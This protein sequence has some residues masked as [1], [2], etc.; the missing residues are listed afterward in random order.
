MATFD[1]AAAGADQP[2]WDLS[3]P[4]E[5]GVII[6]KMDSG[7]TVSRA[8]HERGLRRWS[9]TWEHTNQRTRDYVVGFVRDVLEASEVL[10]WVLPINF[11]YEPRPGVGPAT[12]YT[13]GGALAGTTYYIAY[14]WFNANGE[15]ELSP[16]VSRTVP[17]SHFLQVTVGRFPTGATGAYVYVGTASGALKREATVSTSRGTW[18]Q[19]GALSGSVDPATANGMS[20]TIRARIARGGFSTP[21]LKAPGAWALGLEIEEVFNG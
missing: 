7:D 15:T 9:L 12:N 6:D 13:T 1:P 16:E 10:S 14:A 19:A 2:S 21:V 20:E 5:Y 3:E 4:R 8:K 18:T 17:A 11:L